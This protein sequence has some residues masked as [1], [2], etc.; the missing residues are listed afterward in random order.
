M[1]HFCV[2]PTSQAEEALEDAEDDEEEAEWTGN[3]KK[4]RLRVHPPSL[5]APCCPLP[6]ASRPL[7]PAC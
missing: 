1:V 6:A 4:A 7:A 5:P 2:V 3:Q